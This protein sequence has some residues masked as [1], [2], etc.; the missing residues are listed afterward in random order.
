M[1][2]GCDVALD[3]VGQSF[4]SQLAAF[5]GA[6][7]AA[8][9]DATGNLV[10]GGDW[11]LEYNTGQVD[12]AALASPDYSDSLGTINM[13]TGLASG[14]SS[15]NIG[16][17]A[18]R[19]Y[20]QASGPSGYDTGTDPKWVDQ[21]TGDQH[22][23]YWS[24][25]WGSFTYS[26]PRWG[27]LPWETR[28]VWYQYPVVAD[29][30]YGS[31]TRY[32]VETVQISNDSTYRF[33]ITANALYKDR[34]GNIRT[35]EGITALNTALY[36]G[37]FDPTNPLKNLVTASQNW[38]YAGTTSGLQLGELEAGTYQ[39]VVSFDTNRWF[40]GVDNNVWWSGGNNYA[41]Q[42]WGNFTLNVA[43]L[44][45]A[46]V[47][48]A[49]DLTQLLS[50]S[51][52]QSFSIPWSL[53]GN[54]TLVD[55][56]GDP[57]TITAALTSG[58][59]LPSWLT[60]NP[61]NLSF[62]GNPPPNTGTLNIRLTATDGQLSSTRDFTVTYSN[63]NDRP[64]VA[65]AIPDQ[66]WDGPGGA[67]SYQVPAGTFTDADPNL[68]PNT[69]SL[70]YT[71]TL[72]NGD[73]LPSWLNFDAATRTFSGNPPA[74]FAS[75]DVK[76][77][78]ND[79]S[80]QANAT[81]SDTFRLN[82]RNNNDVPTV[83]DIAKTINE[84]STYSFSAAD[85]VFTDTD[86]RATN[87]TTTGSG[88]TLQFVRIVSLPANGTLWL[89]ADNDNVLD[90][91]EAVLVNQTVTAAN[92]GLLR[93]TPKKDWAGASGLDRSS[94]PDSFQWTAS[95]G[96]NEAAT[97]A[98]TRITV[99]LINDAPVL[100]FSDGRTL[101]VRANTGNPLSTPVRVDAGLTLSDADAPYSSDAAYDTISKVTISITEKVSGS[102]ISGDKLDVTLAHGITKSYN[103]A[104]GVL[105]LSGNARADQYQAVLRTL[106]F[107]STNTSNGRAL[108]PV[109][110]SRETFA[111]ARDATH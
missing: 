35:N 26:V 46:P 23:N 84:D 95:D 66:T 1:L 43:N 75:I 78:A 73:P 11:E 8:S 107:S 6:D 30:N 47:W 64:V 88:K 10:A 85:F 51:D 15:I 76:V 104:T 41:Q 102:F 94:S 86:T 48:T 29:W 4:V 20:W 58:A 98:T 2:Y 80:G 69:Y 3:F 79:G 12:A 110:L 67:F 36:K 50:G 7:V 32:G 54:Q 63:D 57:L 87:D 105:T 49:R 70:T 31:G 37:G 56:D 25:A 9:D 34:N 103:T 28:T 17:Y 45:Q 55:P 19:L 44:N 93:Y 111:I 106:E 82:L 61:N 59:A 14:S 74:N 60:F 16:R 65:E 72:D 97:P 68:A 27:W 42:M 13:S 101:S 91:G 90:D 96:V 39:V 81:Q 92:L 99:N 89:D 24:S 5:T 52:T 109:S 71:A 83:S 22:V 53:S 108:G 38:V 33:D 40:I 62:T 21:Y 18:P 77:T 100:G